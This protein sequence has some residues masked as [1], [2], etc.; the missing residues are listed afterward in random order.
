M[1]E[2][3]KAWSENVWCFVLACCGVFVLSIA[4][5]YVYADITERCDSQCDASTARKPAC[6]N[7]RWNPTGGK[8]GGGGCENEDWLETSGNCT[9]LGY[10]CKC[11]CTPPQN[12]SVGVGKYREG[13]SCHCYY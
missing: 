12:E 10:V 4:I 1:T 11:K 5:E 7:T 8:E 2:K 9:I 6:Q 3:R 13:A